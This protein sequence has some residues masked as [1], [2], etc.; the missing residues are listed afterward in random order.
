MVMLS[1]PLNGIR[2]MI[3]GWYRLPPERENGT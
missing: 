2:A 1:G 3:T